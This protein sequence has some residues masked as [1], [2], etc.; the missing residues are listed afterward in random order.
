[1]TALSFGERGGNCKTTTKI[2][3]L[4]P[5]DQNRVWPKGD[6]LGFEGNEEE[7]GD[8]VKLTQSSS[9]KHFVLRE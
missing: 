7:I 8:I 4:I 3:C 2:E 5:L 1:M 9:D 6:Q